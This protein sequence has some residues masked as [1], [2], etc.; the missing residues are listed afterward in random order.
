MTTGELLALVVGALT[1]LTLLCGLAG[2][3]VRFVLL[4][5]LRDHMV[6]P[7]LDQLEALAGDLRV[8]A[9]MFEGHITHSEQDRARLW[10]AVDELRKDHRC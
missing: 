1:A 7:L 3:L 9:Y 8:A 10:A 6:A 5:W 4:P 2:M